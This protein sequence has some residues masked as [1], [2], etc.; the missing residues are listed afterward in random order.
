MTDRT[1]KLCNLP[2][3]ITKQEIKDAFASYTLKKIH[4]DQNNAYIL[5]ENAEDIETL[6]FTYD[7]LIIP[8]LESASV[9]TVPQDF[10]WE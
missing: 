1:I 6:E 10:K 2:S 8:A 3:N 9:D 4:I 5:L 7:G